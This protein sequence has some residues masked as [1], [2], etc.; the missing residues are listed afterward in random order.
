MKN[1][2]NELYCAH[3]HIA[4]TCEKCYVAS[5]AALEDI[6][7]ADAEAIVEALK[8]PI[9]EPAN[10]TQ[11]GFEVEWKGPGLYSLDSEHIFRQVESFTAAFA[12]PTC[13]TV[14][15]FETAFEVSFTDCG[16]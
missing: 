1:K 9:V 5:L 4:E 15:R 6:S 3:N 14:R 16:I 2:L 12:D 10:F 8:A 13:A 11:D 7:I